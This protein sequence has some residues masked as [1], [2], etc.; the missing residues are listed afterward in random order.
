MA[1]EDP[2]PPPE[3][4]EHALEKKKENLPEE[5]EVIQGLPVEVIE[6][7]PPDLRKQ[8]VSFSMDHRYIG[9]APNPI[10]GKLTDRA[11]RQNIRV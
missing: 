8:I 10:L 6:K 4:P 2:L 1:E 7:L 11:H 3:Q 9:P 5:G